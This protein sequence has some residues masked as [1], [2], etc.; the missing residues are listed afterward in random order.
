MNW[1]F[2]AY[3]I[4][5]PSPSKQKHFEKFF[6]SGCSELK[7]LQTLKTSSKSEM[8]S[9]YVNFTNSGIFFFEN[10]NINPL[11]VTNFLN[12]KVSNIKQFMNS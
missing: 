2:G 4:L 11:D 8:F 12:M 1:T 10:L 7:A 5:S 6:F 9:T 3:N